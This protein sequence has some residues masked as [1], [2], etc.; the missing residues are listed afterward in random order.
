MVTFL[1]SNVVLQISAAMIFGG[2]IYWL[3]TIVALSRQSEARGR[4]A[5]LNFL[6]G[7]TGI[8]WMWAMIWA[9]ASTTGYR[10]PTGPVILPPERQSRN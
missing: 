8:G 3:P 5:A 9:I 4:I 7:W 10:G 1:L 6:V 2:L